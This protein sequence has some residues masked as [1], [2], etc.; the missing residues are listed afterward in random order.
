MSGSIYN[1]ATT[2]MSRRAGVAS[3]EVNG[4]ALD[5]AGDLAYDA[6]RMK[7]EE[8]DGQSGPQGYSEMPKYGFISATVRD[9]GTLS[10]QRM[11]ELTNVPVVGV[12]ATGKTVYGDSLTCME[13]SEVKTAEGTFDVKFVGYVTESSY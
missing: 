13:C 10:Q 8:L 7:R 11:M 5:V 9:A 2:S 3:L 6:T 12:T 4:E 1:G